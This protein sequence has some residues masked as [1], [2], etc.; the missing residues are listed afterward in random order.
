MQGSTHEDRHAESQFGYR[1]KQAVRFN[2]SFYEGFEVG[3]VK[4][5]SINF[6]QSCLV[7]NTDGVLSIMVI[8]QWN[9]KNIHFSGCVQK[10][11]K[12][13]ELT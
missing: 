2:T 4:I 3:L 9:S 5:P 8:G 12:E 6:L 1:H 7:H 11:H 10:D 13:N